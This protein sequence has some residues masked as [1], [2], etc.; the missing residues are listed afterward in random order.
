MWSEP[1]YQVVFALVC[2]MTIDTT[3]HKET[4]F[5]CL[6]FREQVST[7][8]NWSA[9]Q[10]NTNANTCLQIH[11]Q[12][13]CTET[14][15]RHLL[16]RKKSAWGVLKCSGSRMAHLILLERK[17]SKSNE[18]KGGWQQWVG[19]EGGGAEE[20][21]AREETNVLVIAECKTKNMMECRGSGEHKPYSRSN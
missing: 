4:H 20:A 8:S 5:I 7:R 1:Q 16:Y 11:L 17:E 6:T 13:T 14:A 15:W 9:K 10:C 19:A 21:N 2:S 12:H 18:K 3:G